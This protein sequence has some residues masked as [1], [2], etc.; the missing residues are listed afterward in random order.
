MNSAEADQ[1]IA[2]LD[3]L[4]EHRS[5][6]FSDGHAMRW[7]V[8]GSGD[9]L[10]LF[11]G[12]H[13]SWLHW[14]RNIEALARTH[15]VFV[16]DLPG[17]GDSDDPPA[18]ADIPQIADAVMASLNALLGS[19][20]VV[21]LAGFSFGAVVG[22]RIAVKRGA[23]R[24]FALLGSPGSGTPQRRR[25]QMIRWR[26]ADAA[27]QDAAL[28]HNLLAH[29]MSA[30][31]NVDALAFRAYVDALKATR[32]RSHGASHEVMLQEILAPYTGPVL[33]LYGEHDVVCTPQM[34]KHSL[35]NADI[36]RE[37]RVIPDGGHWIQFER[38]NEVNEALA[39]W[40]SMSSLPT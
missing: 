20:C 19:Q 10:V 27:A 1:Y 7:R 2:R 39:R 35:S 28:R 33:F 29:M 16:P 6:A 3:A 9:P 17:F 25:A 36:Q 11:H 26:K 4:A 12:G 31:S 23:V 21:N 15:Q 37:C 13:G 5:A 32:Y 24:R 8:F 30:A 18:D 38:A 22:A 14:I 34:A 40:F